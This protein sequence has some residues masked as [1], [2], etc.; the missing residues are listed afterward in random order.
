MIIFGSPCTSEMRTAI[1]EDT[2]RLLVLILTLMHT[3]NSLKS[4][5]LETLMGTRSSARP[6]GRIGLRKLWTICF[7]DPFST[8]T[9]TATVEDNAIKYKSAGVHIDKLKST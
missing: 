8:L 1:E 5:S 3:R 4:V 2:L 7:E 6:L 9:N